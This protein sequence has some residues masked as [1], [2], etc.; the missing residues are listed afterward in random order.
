MAVRSIQPKNELLNANIYIDYESIC[1]LLRRYGNNPMELNFFQ[2][3]LDY[4]KNVHKLNIIDCIVYCDFEKEAFPRKHQT[5]LYN[6]GIRFRHVA[7]SGKDHNNLMMAVNAITTLYKNPN[8]NVFV[9]ISSGWDMVPLL[10]LIKYENK[11]VYVNFSRQDFD[12]DVSNFVAYCEYL[13][14]I[15][16]LKSEKIVPEEAPEVGFLPDQIDLLYRGCDTPRPVK[17]ARLFSSSAMWRGIA[18]W[19]VNRLH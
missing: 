8:I 3:I 1:K 19:Q 15:F 17:A 4:Y 18:R 9:L 16:N 12:L 10:K 7:P 2:V 6:C 11:A 14:D 5:A 13:E